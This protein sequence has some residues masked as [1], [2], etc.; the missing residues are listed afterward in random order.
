M[1]TSTI[2]RYD[3]EIGRWNV[4]DLLAEKMRMHSPY[5]YAFDN[6]I[7]FIDPDGRNPIIPWSFRT[8]ATQGGR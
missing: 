5:N 2:T 7:R 4:V 8:L 3:E 6:P 1:A